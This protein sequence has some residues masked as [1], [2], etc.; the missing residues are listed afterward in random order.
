MQKCIKDSLKL[1]TQMPF[2]IQEGHI[3]LRNYIQRCNTVGAFKTMCTYGNP[4]PKIENK[5]G[6]ISRYN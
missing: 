6:V 4:L 2:Q 1:N 3:L 5:C